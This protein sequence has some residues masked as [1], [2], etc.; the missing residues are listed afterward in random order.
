MKTTQLVL[1]DKAFDE[2]SGQWDELARRGMTDTPF[3][4]LAYQRSWWKNLQPEDATLL[5]G[6]VRD[7]DGT[8]QAIGCFYQLE[9]T[10]YFNGCVEETDYLDVICPAEH[11]SSSWHELL[12]C[13][14]AFDSPPWHS[15]E[16]CNI[17]ES[18]Q[19]RNILSNLAQTKGY[20]YEE[21]VIEVCPIISLPA[22]FDTY[23]ESLDSKQRR[24]IS[25]KMRRAEGA[26][27]RTVIIGPE[28]DLAEAVDL[29]LDLLQLSTFEKRDWLHDGRRAVFHEV[30]QAAQQ[31]GL[32]QLMF[33]EHE[34]RKAA[35]LFNFDYKD[36]IW[37]YNSGLDPALFAPLS[38]G[39]VLTAAAIEHAINLGRSEFDFMR[40]SEDYK[41]RFGAKDTH[42][43][44][45]HIDRSAS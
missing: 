28:D 21:E 35:G 3:Q 11:A 6:A 15:L 32:L 27:M 26:E 4:L 1:G 38:P 40:G 20:R 23:L 25:R 33:V 8:L 12:D 5:T 36:R 37:V 7:T 44:R 30:A 34:G 42:I 29:F 41:Y 17:P 24:E 10:L 31:A 18:S 39:V 19:T 13:L 22:T 45:I 43:Y 16:L 9:G 14:E 2:L